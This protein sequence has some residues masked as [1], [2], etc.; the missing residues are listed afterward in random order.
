VSIA[1]SSACF[2]ADRNW[3]ALVDIYRRHIQVETEAQERTAV[4]LALGHLFEEELRDPDRAAESYND[5]LGFDP[6]HT[7]A[8]KGLR[9]STSRP[10]SGIARSR[11]WSGW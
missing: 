9:A 10:S 2:R 11:S 5:I 8:L 3:D 1:T 6:D 4:H 7:E